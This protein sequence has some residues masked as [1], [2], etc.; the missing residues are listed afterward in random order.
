MA[1]TEDILL[2]GVQEMN[3]QENVWYL[4]IGASSHMMNKRSYFH[5]IEENQLGLI[6]FGGESS[7]RFEGKGSIVMNYL[8]GEEVKLEGVLFAPSVK[9]NTLSLGKLDEDGFTSTLGAGFLSISDN[10]GKQFVT[11]RKTNGSMY[12]LK[13]GVFEFCQI[14]QE[15]Y[16]EVW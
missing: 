5:S 12:L 13:L 4:D 16:Q 8:D 2:Q 11:I 1:Y 6:R 9:V 3:L 15:E 14:T 7:G 10:E